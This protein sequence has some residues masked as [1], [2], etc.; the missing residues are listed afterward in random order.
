M[1][2]V[3]PGELHWMI[4]IL[5]PT[6]TTDS[7]NPYVPGQPREI[8]VRAAVRAVKSQDAAYTAGAERAQ[9]TLQFIVRW[10]TGIDTSAAVIYKGRRYELEYVDPAPFAGNYMRLR[11]VSYDAGV[12]EVTQ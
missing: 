5:L 7:N 1:A 11:G 4:S 9:E 6:R 12:G 3:D 8:R 2:H 10:R